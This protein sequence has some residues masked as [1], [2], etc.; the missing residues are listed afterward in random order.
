MN[1]KRYFSKQIINSIFPRYIRGI[2]KS[3]NCSVHSCTLQCVPCWLCYCTCVCRTK[4]YAM[5]CKHAG[6]YSLQS[7]HYS[8]TKFW[9]LG[10]PCRN[11]HAL[12]FLSAQRMSATVFWLVILLVINYNNTL[13][14]LH[15]LTT[16]LQY[17]LQNWSIFY[18]AVCSVHN[19]S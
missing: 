16:L 15:L 1:I 3:Y 18:A 19:F 10:S 6:I 13:F 17:N 9:E 4:M 7:L 14:S 5:Q 2:C 8:S 12:F 11:L